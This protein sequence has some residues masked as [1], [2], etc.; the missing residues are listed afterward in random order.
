L[1]AKGRPTAELVREA[2]SE[3]TRR[4]TPRTKARS[5]GAGASRRGDLSEKAED[6]LR[7]MGR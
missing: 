2:V 4:N 1:K 6:L 3:Y 5:I 7:G